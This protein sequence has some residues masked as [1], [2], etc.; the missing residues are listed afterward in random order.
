MLQVHIELAMEEVVEGLVL[1]GSLLLT[2]GLTM[3]I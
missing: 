2:V 3:E 1:K